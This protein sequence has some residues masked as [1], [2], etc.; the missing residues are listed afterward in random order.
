LGEASEP[1]G[2]VI[3]FDSGLKR[4]GGLPWG[5]PLPKRPTL[6]DAFMQKKASRFG[7]RSQQLVKTL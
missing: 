5:K 3:A 7:I 4:I 2:I 6:D 1:D